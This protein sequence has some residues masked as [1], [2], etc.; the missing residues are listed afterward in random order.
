MFYNDTDDTVHFFLTSNSQSY[1][2]DEKLDDLGKLK[3]YFLV[4]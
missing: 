4:T 3:G 1:T 2:F